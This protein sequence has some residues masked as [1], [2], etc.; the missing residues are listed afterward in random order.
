M[1]V[2]FLDVDGVLNACRRV[3]KGTKGFELIDWVL[4][5]PIAHVNRI[6]RVT[7]AKIVI[8]STWRVGKTVEEL[9]LM[10]GGVGVLGDV[11]DKT[12]SGP[13]IWHIQKGFDQCYEGH[14]GAEIAEWL[15]R[16]PEV[17]S[18]AILDDDGDMGEVRARF[19]QTVGDRGLVRAQCDRVIELLS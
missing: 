17:T 4:P 16:H 3:T 8:S 2:L 6:C 9:R 10:F 12:E 7:G 1:K 13:C 19:V 11:I 18:Y 5:G 14:R 15:S